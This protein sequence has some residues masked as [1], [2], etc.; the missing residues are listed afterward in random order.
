[1][2]HKT[3]TAGR[4]VLLLREAKK[5]TDVR[6]SSSIKVWQI[7]L[8]VP[9]NKVSLVLHRY[10][11]ILEMPEQI[12]AQVLRQEETTHELFL[13][14]MPKI[15]AAFKSCILDAQFAAF[16]D[17]IDETTLQALEFCSDLLGRKAP[18]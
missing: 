8:K 13:R 5:R 18:E 2:D 12:K 1:M 6:G 17:Q 9:E 16:I 3:N 14:W 10:G 15:E 11:Q 7:L 4:L